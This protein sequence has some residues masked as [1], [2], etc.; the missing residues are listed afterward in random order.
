M[1]R[2]RLSGSKPRVAVGVQHCMVPGG[3]LRL[4][5]VAAAP[6]AGTSESGRL[7]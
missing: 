7:C 4:P 5:K 3:T 2:V 1:I 6:V